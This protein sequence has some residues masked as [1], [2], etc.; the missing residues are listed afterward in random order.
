MVAISILMQTIRFTMCPSEESESPRMKKSS[1]VVSV[2]VIFAS[3]LALTGCG[4]DRD[5]DCAAAYRNAVLKVDAVAS[6]EFECGGSFG[7]ETENGTVAIAVD[8]QEE[9]T[10]VI[11]DIYQSF[12]ADPGLIDA[13][14]PYIEFVSENGEAFNIGEILDELGFGGV[15]S[16]SQMREKYGITPTPTP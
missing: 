8:T 2:A 3:S 4:A 16:V 11:E 10:P 13:R 5:E 7:A 6:A 14:L 12:A 15:P 9:A 1:H